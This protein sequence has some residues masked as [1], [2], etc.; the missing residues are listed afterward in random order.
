MTFFLHFN[1][2]HGN[3]FSFIPSHGHLRRLSR[4]PAPQEVGAGLGPPGIGPPG[5]GSSGIDSGIIRA[6]DRT[7]TTGR[8]SRAQQAAPLRYPSLGIDVQSP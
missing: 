2:H 8:S 5:V 7:Q 4:F 1:N 3:S 6:F